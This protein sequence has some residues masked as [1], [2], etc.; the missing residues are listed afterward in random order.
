MFKSELN[1]KKDAADSYRSSVV[2]SQAS[3]LG[4]FRSNLTWNLY[5]QYLIK[6]FG[7]RKM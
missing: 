1:T 7:E 2:M 4:S 6:Q 3:N 5:I